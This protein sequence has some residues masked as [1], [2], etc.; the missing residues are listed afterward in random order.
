MSYKM[1]Q[2][3]AKGLSKIFL[4]GEMK[5]LYDLM[6]V[7]LEDQPEMEMLQ[8]MSSIQGCV[9]RTLV[10]YMNFRQTIVQIARPKAVALRTKKFLWGL[11]LLYF[12]N[13]LIRSGQKRQYVV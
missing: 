9:Q 8:W 12:A 10:A 3:S 2:A 7:A 4:G 1:A 5:A 11:Y 6:K 13:H